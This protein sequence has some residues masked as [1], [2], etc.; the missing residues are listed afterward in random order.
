MSKTSPKLKVLI[1]DDAELN[2]EMLGEMLGNDYEIIEAEHGAQAVDILY[3]HAADISLILLDVQMPRMDGFEVL[4]Q[5]NRHHWIDAIPVIMISS[6][7]APG[8]I[9]R[10]YDLGATDYIA[11]PYNTMIV[12]RRVANVILSFAKQR[13]LMEIVTQQIS[14]K[15]KD[16]RLML[17]ILSHIV[18]FRNG[19]SGLHVL[20]INVIT[21]LLLRRLM[22][23]NGCK[24]LTNED[25]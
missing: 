2:R 20:H 17:S 22:L 12:R 9:E 3:E 7:I 21:D 16:N 14:K 24:K 4:M 5:M 19:E 18:E 25:I 15:E 23:K 13:Q 1:V 11:R 8:C 6:E 10:A